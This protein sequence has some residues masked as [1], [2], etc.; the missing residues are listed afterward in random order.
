MNN[1]NKFRFAI[2]LFGVLSAFIITACSDN[3]SPDDPS[4]GENTL[5]VKQVSL[6]RKTAYGNDWI[7]YSLEKGKEVSVSEESHAENTDWDIAFNR[8][9][10]ST[11]AVHPA[12]EKVEHYSLTLKIWQPVRQF[13]REHLLSTQPI[14]SLLPAQVSLLLSMESTAN[15]VLCKS[16][17]LPAPSHLHP[18]RLRIYRSHSQWE[19]CQVESQEFL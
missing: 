18:K 2:L 7:Y 10:C 8:Y 9:K 3:N 16:T 13:R 17:T 14:P 15:E 11:T 19:I 5:P 6:S 4:Q 1:K 12:K